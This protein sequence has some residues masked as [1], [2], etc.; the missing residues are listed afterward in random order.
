MRK[1]IS[2]KGKITLWYLALMAV[3]GLALLLLVL[4]ISQSVTSSDALERLRET[5]LEDVSHLSWDETK[6]SVVMDE[7][8]VYYKDGISLLIYSKNQSLLA[9]Q[10]PVSFTARE[11]FEN[12][13]LRQVD[14]GSALFYVVD[15]W[16]PFDWENGVW[17]RGIMEVPKVEGELGRIRQI[18]LLLLPG[19]LLLA[20]IGGYIIVWRAF[21]P[22]E[23]ITATAAAIGEGTDLVARVEAPKG[24]N[25]VTKLADTFNQMFGRLEKAFETEKQFTADASH[26]LRTPISVIKG[27]CQYGLEY[28]E[29][30]EDTRETLEMIYRQA[31]K[32]GNLVEQLLGM[33]RLDQGIEGKNLQLVSLSP[34]LETLC[35]DI[36]GVSHRLQWR[37]APDLQVMGSGPLLERMVRNLIENGLKYS[38]D[39]EKVNVTAEKDGAFCRISVEDKGIG[40]APEQQEKIWTRFYQVDT[41]RSQDGGAGL[42]LSMVQKILQ[43]HGGQVFL[44]SK[45]G[46]GSRFTILLPVPKI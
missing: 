18:A 33:T 40:I 34:L 19:M 41:S 16:R 7:G 11:P 22:L 37:I 25:E 8:M 17:I 29:T 20:G 15:Y 44:E 35:Q 13:S 21:R 24:K 30:K 43:L 28:D 6:G 39:T 42:G 2:I 12:G 31:E 32:M 38:E 36:D 23:K 3:L 27:A 5:A 10:I 1:G 9:G 14:C 26:E 4:Y 45:V 46:E